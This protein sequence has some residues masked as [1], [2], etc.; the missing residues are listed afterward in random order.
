MINTA[1]RKTLYR[2]PGKGK[3][4]GVCAG[5]A[6]YY[7][8][9][10]WVVRLVVIILGFLTGFGLVFFIY[11]AAFFILDPKPNTSNNEFDE[12]RKNNQRKRDKVKE[13]WQEAKDTF[14][15][16]RVIS[17]KLLDNCEQK[18]ANVKHSVE[19]MEAFVTSSKFHLDEEFK[20]IK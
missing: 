11:M 16:E 20:K 18:L 3:I 17:K 8:W 9:D 15:G 6:D 1:T 10:A 2:I 4:C 19:Q 7:N 5:V 12:H 13:R 14:S